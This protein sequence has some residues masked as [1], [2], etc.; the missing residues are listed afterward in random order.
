MEQY[1]HFGEETISELYKLIHSPERNDLFHAGRR[2]AKQYPVSNQ[3][4]D[5]L[6]ADHLFLSNEGYI[7]KL[8]EFNEERRIKRQLENE[9]SQI[10]SGQANGNE[11][12]KKADQDSILNF[13]NTLSFNVYDS[14]NKTLMKSEKNRKNDDS[15]LT[16]AL[17]FMIGKFINQVRFFHS[18]IRNATNLSFL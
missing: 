7:E 6:D 15:S 10:S 1:K 12:K 3:V 17:N 11:L 16:D 5:Q 2:F 8:N 9:A 18:R 4:E 14:L 13:I